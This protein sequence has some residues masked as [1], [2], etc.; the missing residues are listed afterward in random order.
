MP[1]LRSSLGKVPCLMQL[2][3][4]RMFGLHGLLFLSSCDLALSCPV[5]PFSIW[6]SW[7]YRPSFPTPGHLCAVCPDQALPTGLIYSEIVNPFEM[8]TKVILFKIYMMI[9]KK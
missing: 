1:L 2:L 5:L 9:Y 6:L 8:K 7:V 4:T 3:H